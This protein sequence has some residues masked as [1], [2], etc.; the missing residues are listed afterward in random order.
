MLRCWCKANHSIR[1][2]PLGDAVYSSRADTG[3]VVAQRGCNLGVGGMLQ[4]AKN[5][6]H[7][8]GVFRRPALH[9]LLHAAIVIHLQ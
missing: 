4:L 7:S 5:R 3:V 1:L 2:Q 8:I 9:C 6:D